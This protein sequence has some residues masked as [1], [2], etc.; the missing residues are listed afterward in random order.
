LIG[1]NGYILQGCHAIQAGQV[2]FYHADAPNDYRNINAE[3]VTGQTATGRQSLL[4]EPGATLNPLASFLSQLAPE[5]WEA[6]RGIPYYRGG[7]AT[8]ARSVGSLARDY[9][10]HAAEIEAWAKSI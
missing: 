9:R 4:A 10:E 1:W 3:F 2:P 7:L 8:I 5:E 6:D